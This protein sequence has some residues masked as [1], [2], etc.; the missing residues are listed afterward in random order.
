MGSLKPSTRIVLP[1]LAWAGAVVSPALAQDA[2]AG[3]GPTAATV[4]AEVERVLRETS[5]PAISI[6]LVRRGEVVW[7]EA[8]GI[9]NLATGA[10]ATTDTYFSTGSTLKPATA[11]A[12][13]QLVDQG[14]ISLDD[15]VNDLV[16]DDLAIAGADEVTLRQLLAHHAGLDGPVD[17]V[18]LWSREPLPTLA[19]TVPGLAA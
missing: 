19:E 2:N 8:W 10:R 16:G 18:P 3:L 12:V 14:R 15:R 13:L 4:R 17:I 7:S 6:S 9:A 5:I 11:A 1:L